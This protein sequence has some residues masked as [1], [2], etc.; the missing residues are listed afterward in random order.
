MHS[1][2]DHS[3]ALT[4]RLE[5][6]ATTLLIMVALLVGGFA[7]WDRVHPEPV[8][9][10][11]PEEPPP[12]EPVSLDGATIRGNRSAKVALI[13][14]SDFECSYCAKAA[15]DL[16]PTL[17]RQYLQTGKVLLAWRHYPLEFH[18]LAPKA[19]EAVECAGREGK[20]W[21]F[22]DWA[23]EHQ[24]QLEQPNLRAAA[25]TLGLDST[26][27]AACLD[28]GDMASK[29]E[30]DVTAGKALAVSGTPSWFIGVVQTDGRVKIAERLSG[31]KPLPDF[32]KVID[33]VVASAANSTN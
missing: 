18:K 28:S 31:A 14:F 11:R 20:F 9:A 10:A 17:D 8:R 30:A 23:F 6:A 27:F 32:Q 24:N 15:R 1:N 3:T 33:R 2:K 29:V 21:E 5:L 16:M 4:E 22:H 26:S 25:S 12:R 13:V 19:A 7:V